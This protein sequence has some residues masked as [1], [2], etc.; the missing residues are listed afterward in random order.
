LKLNLSEV[1]DDKPYKVVANIPYYITSKILRYFLEQENKPETIVLLTQKEV[2]EQITAKPG[3]MSLLSVSVQA[4]GE[5][6]IVGIVKAGSFFPAP[7]VDSA[8]LKIKNIHSFSHPEQGEGSRDDDKSARMRPG[9][10][11]LDSSAM[12]QNDNI[13]RLI[14][15][16]NFFRC[17]RIGFSSK[18]KTLLNNLSAGYHLDKEKVLD[19]LIKSGLSENTRAQELG[20]EAWKKLSQM[21]ERE[22]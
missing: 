1:V 18:R 17:V 5:P 4:Y 13:E 20:I 12:P 14:P 15:D 10:S 19:I 22:L 21:I 6:E 2:A 11:G 16:K 7:K 8:I 9:T 3:Q